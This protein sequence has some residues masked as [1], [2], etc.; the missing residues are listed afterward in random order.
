MLG[1]RQKGFNMLDNTNHEEI[2]LPQFFDEPNDFSSS[3]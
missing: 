3:L 1:E 2:G